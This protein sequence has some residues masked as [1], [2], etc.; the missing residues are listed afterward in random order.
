MRSTYKAARLD[1]HWEWMKFLEGNLIT[2]V[3]SSI[4]GNLQLITQSTA[5]EQECL[6]RAHPQIITSF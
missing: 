3:Y 1:L 5:L 2:R 6:Q 4:L